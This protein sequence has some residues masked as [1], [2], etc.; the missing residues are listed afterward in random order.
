M[1]YEIHQ[2][3]KT[4]SHLT[5]RNWANIE[6]LLVVFNI[7]QLISK[8]VNTTTAADVALLPSLMLPSM[9]VLLVFTIAAILLYNLASADD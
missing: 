5:I 7:L 2:L 4:T 9:A 6:A 1:V 3:E 8:L